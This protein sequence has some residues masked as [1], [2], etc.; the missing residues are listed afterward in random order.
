MSYKLRVSV[1]QKLRP[2]VPNLCSLV[3]VDDSV[4]KE[5]NTTKNN[6]LSQCYLLQQ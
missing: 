3:E 4:E 2:Y 6:L 1:K 5:S